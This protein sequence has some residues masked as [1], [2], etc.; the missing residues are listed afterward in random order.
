MTDGEDGVQVSGLWLW[1]RSDS[2]ESGAVVA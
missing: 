2:V 1:S